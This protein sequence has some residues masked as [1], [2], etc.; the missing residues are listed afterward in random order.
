VKSAQ[1]LQG[2]GQYNWLYSPRFY[3]GFR[4]AGAYDGIAELDYRITITPLA[5]YYVVKETNTTFAV[6]IGPSAVFEKH[7]GQSEDSYVGLRLSERLEHNLSKTAKVWEKVDYVPDVADW[8]GRYVI[9]AEAGIDSAITKT[10]SLRLVMQDIYDSAPA[11][12]RQSN[13]FRLIAGT[14]YKF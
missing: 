8:G 4:V 2:F 5:G 9:T 1:F 12:G 14:A 11:A 6:E 7:T 13:D 10:W 3:A